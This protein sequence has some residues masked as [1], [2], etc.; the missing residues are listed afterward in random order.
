VDLQFHN[1]PATFRASVFE[2]YNLDLDLAI[3]EIP[4]AN[5]PAG[6]T[7][8]SRKDAAQ[9]VPV[10]VIGHPTAGDWSVVPASVQGVSTPD[11]KIQLFTTTRDSSLAEGYSGGAVFDSD[12]L[13]L[14]MHTASAPTYGIEA[15]SGD[16]ANQLRAWHVPTNNLL[17]PTTRAQAEVEINRLLDNYEDAYTRKDASALWVVWPD[18]SAKI[19]GNVVSSFEA[20]QSIDMKVTNRQVVVALDGTTATA[21]GE[22]VQ[23]YTAKRQSP[24]TTRG[25]ITFT[26]EK[27]AR[28][29]V[30]RSIK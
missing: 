7:E 25:N 8:V 13:F 14:G 23:R 27:R 3:V 21:T 28:T 1:S 26:L 18:V 9:G 24:E 6:L 12:G 30:I 20:A 19:R 11:G 22:Y 29:W 17:D 5:L 16:I 4:V 15:K 2:R 10:H